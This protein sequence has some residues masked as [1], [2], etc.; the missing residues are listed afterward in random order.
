M[1]KFSLGGKTLMIGIK[2]EDRKPPYKV[3][4]ASLPKD[5]YQ[6]VEKHLTHYGELTF[7]IR[8]FLAE[9]AAEK[10]KANP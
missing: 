1:K 8:Q 9:W 10:E 7:I 6:R 5:E 4:R 3:I 2:K